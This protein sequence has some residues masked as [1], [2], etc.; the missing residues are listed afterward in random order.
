MTAVTAWWGLGYAALL[1][2]AIVYGWHA[3]HDILPSRCRLPGSSRPVLRWTAHLL[4]AL[5]SALLWIGLWVRAQRGHGWPI[6]TPADAAA[7]IALLLL[8]AH[9]V[10]CLV[11]PRHPAGL[12]TTVVA[13]ALLSYGMS[14]FPRGPVTL[15]PTHRL[16]LLSGAL[17]LCAGSLM[18]LAATTSLTNVACERLPWLAEEHPPSSMAED[19]ASATLVWAALFC[20]ATSLAID[21]WSLQRVGL[22]AGNDAQ[23]AGIAVAWMVYFVAIRLRS[24]ERWRGWPWASVLAVGFVCTLPILI[25]VPWLGNRLP[26]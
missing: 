24:D 11:E 12:A 21:T 22:G 6:V 18:A 20:L 8:L 4:T 2:C 17:N 10:W 16:S 26:L 9:S 14:Q 15:A 25:N 19:Q 1:V 3:T 23:Q 13:L 5:S 7:G